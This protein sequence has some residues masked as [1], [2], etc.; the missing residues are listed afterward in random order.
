MPYQPRVL[1]VDDDINILSAFEGFLKTEHCITLTSSRP[2]EALHILESQQVSLVITDIR[3]KYRSGVTLLIHI[4]HLYPSL[5][6]IVITGHPHL[7]TEEDIRRFGANYYFLKPLELDPL[8]E[9]VRKCLSLSR[10]ASER[11]PCIQY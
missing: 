1:I 8:R 7:I 4:R 6:V 11:T 3:L 2:E 5:P 9:A 10:L